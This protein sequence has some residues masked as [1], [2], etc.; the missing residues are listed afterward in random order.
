MTLIDGT[1]PQE[2]AFNTLRQNSLHIDALPGTSPPNGQENLYRSSLWP[3]TTTLLLLLSAGPAQNGLQSTWRQARCCGL[4]QWLPA[5]APPLPISRRRRFRSQTRFCKKA[6][7]KLMTG[8]FETDVCDSN[9]AGFVL[10]GCTGNETRRKCSR[11]SFVQAKVGLQLHL[12]SISS[13]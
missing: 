5:T 4:A 2:H 10:S 11:G 3:V 13:G 1:P 6:F 12:Q 8:S 7:G 9:R